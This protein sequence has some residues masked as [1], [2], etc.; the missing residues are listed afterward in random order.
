MVT[1]KTIEKFKKYIGKTFGCIR[2][3]SLDLSK[4]NKNRVYFNC[5]CLQ[6]GNKLRVRSDGICGK[7]INRVAC[8]KCIGTWR[9][10]HFEDLDKEKPIPRD[11]RNKFN[12]FRNNAI[13]RGINFDLTKDQVYE[14]CNKDCVYCGKKRCL[15]IDRVDNSKGYTIDNVVPCCGCCNKMKMDL[16]I[17]FFIDQITKIYNNIKTIKSSSTISK[18]STSETIADGNGVHL[19]FKRR[20][21]DIVKSA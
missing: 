9:S 1:E 3:D 8:Q 19:R 6:C 13:N 10:K 20:D 2:T 17:N 15:G 18:E 12:H 5:T 21:G 16:E 4:I 7:N 14:L 11:M